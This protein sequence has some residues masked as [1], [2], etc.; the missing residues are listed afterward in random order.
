MVW[1]AVT[2]EEYEEED[3]REDIVGGEGMGSVHMG[4]GGS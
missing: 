4:W 3:V 2:V 1:L